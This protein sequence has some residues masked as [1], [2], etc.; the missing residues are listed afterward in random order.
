MDGAQ[1]CGKYKD[2]KYPVHTCAKSQSPEYLYVST[3]QGR[4]SVNYPAQKGCD[5]HNSKTYEPAPDSFIRASV[6]VRHKSAA[7]IRSMTS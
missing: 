6:M 7:T 5:Q 1:E 4:S 3:A 2:R